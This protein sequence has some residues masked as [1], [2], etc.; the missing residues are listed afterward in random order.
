MTN[1]DFVTEKWS[2]TVMNTQ[3]H[4]QLY[5]WVMGRNW[6]IF[7]VNTRNVDIKADSDE[8]FHM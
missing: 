1:T 5:N 7:Y 3:I 2:A 4:K 6:K 8:V